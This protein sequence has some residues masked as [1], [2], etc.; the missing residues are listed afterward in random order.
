MP[1]KDYLSA[2]ARHRFD[3]PPILPGEQ[4]QIFLQVARRLK[5][6]DAAIQFYAEYVINNQIPQVAAR[7]TIR[8][9][10][11]ISFII[12]QYYLL[13]NALILTLNEV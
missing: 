6:S 11:L 4:R 13:G 8:Y 5:L 3:H 10:L 12:H 2:E 7:S 9:L 1:R